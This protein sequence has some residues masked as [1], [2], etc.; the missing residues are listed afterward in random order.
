[1]EKIPCSV[2][3]LTKNVGDVLVRALDTAREFDEI[4]IVDGGSS[5]TTLAIARS[6]GATVISQNDEYKNEDGSIRD[7]SGVRNQYLSEAKYDWIFALDADEY[8][9]PELVDEIRGRVATDPAVYWVPRKYE[10]NGVVIERAVNYPSRQ[11]RFFNR[12]A[13]RGYIKPVHER[14]NVKEDFPTR[15]LHSHMIVPITDDFEATKRKWRKYIA[16]ERARS[17]GVSFRKWL[18]GTLR[19]CSLMAFY[20]LRLL[21]MVFFQRGARLPVGM[22]VRVFWYQWALI[23]SQFSLIRRF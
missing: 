18:R 8:I 15:T 6:Y 7:F 14:L 16:L 13:V 23:R 19:E 1:M 5:D 21:R 2:C 22:E 20:A 12:S 4:M 10:F 17:Q 3:I 11:I 9:S